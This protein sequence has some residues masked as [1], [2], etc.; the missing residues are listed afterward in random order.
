[1]VRAD[2]DG[3]SGR[4]PL[5]HETFFIREV[6]WDPGG[7]LAVAVYPPLGAS[8]GADAGPIVLIPTDADTPATPLA[9]YGSALR[10]GP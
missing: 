7:E 1:M 9:D 6:L 4:T 3:V 2:A 8:T 10:W 5:R